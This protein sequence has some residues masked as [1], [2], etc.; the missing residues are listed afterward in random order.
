LELQFTDGIGLKHRPVVE[1]SSAW[2]P[3]DSYFDDLLKRIESHCTELKVQLDIDQLRLSIKA[4]KD[5]QEMREAELQILDSEGSKSRRNPFVDS[6]R[7]SIERLEDLKRTR[8]EELVKRVC[9]YEEK[10]DKKE[11]ERKYAEQHE[12]ERR[13]HQNFEA[14]QKNSEV[15]QIGISF[16]SPNTIIECFLTNT[17]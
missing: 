1:I 16:P 7:E 5:M 9:D 12:E 8:E 17:F 15:A 14:F 3:F 2:Q 6:L 11:L 10:E 4:N 13:R